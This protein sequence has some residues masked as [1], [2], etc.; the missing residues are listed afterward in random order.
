[1]RM[2]QGWAKLNRPGLIDLEVDTLKQGSQQD[3]EMSGT[4]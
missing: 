3:R 1:M 2:T 4:V